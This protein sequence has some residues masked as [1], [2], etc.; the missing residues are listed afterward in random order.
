MKPYQEI[1]RDLKKLAELAIEAAQFCPGDFHQ[2]KIE[3]SI[4]KV[5]GKYY[6][7]KRQ[8]PKFKSI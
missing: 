8:Y 1:N 4:K 6:S 5:L 3:R 7:K 2:V